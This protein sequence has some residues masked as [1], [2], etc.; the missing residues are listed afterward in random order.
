MS[1]GKKNGRDPKKAKKAGPPTATLPF[2]PTVTPLAASLPA[3]LKHVIAFTGAFGSGCTTAATHVARAFGF[4]CVSLSKVVRTAW[5]EEHPG[6]N[7]E[8]APRAELQAIGDR[9]REENGPAHLVERGLSAHSD[10]PLIVI[11]GI[12]NTAEIDHLRRRFGYN[13]TVIAVLA[14]FKSRWARMRDK[15]HDN[16]NKFLDDDRRDQD[17]DS[18][19]GQQVGLCVDRSDVFLENAPPMDQDGLRDKVTDYVK[20]VTG[21][22]ER[23]PTTEEYFMHMA[24]SA[25]HRSEC[26]KRHVGAIVVDVDGEVAGVGYNENPRGT[27]PCKHEP[28]Y[29]G[30][31]YRDILRE[32]HLIKLTATGTWCPH[33]GAKLSLM[34]KGPFICEACKGNGVKTNLEQS[35]FP[36]RAM[37]WCTAIHAEAAALTSAGARA[38]GGTIYTTTFP[39]FQC[40][41][42]IK[43]AGI[44]QVYYTDP[45]PDA[46]SQ[47]RLLLQKI[48]TK[49]FEGVRSAS[50]ER[51][52]KLAK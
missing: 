15:Y 2:S 14:G 12:R 44:R 20:L 47:G 28:E 29:E 40:T 32:R 23:R 34:L 50:F 10:Q 6:Q 16:L 37:W 46:D 33:C 49:R 41:E 52:F 45:Y 17:E 18:E 43:Q 51:V 30:R 5:K 7:G 4:H 24:F 39:C 3:G 19:F 31:C 25:A 27:L 8:D 1:K 22:I 26:L 35:F 21:A 36:D 38:R 48:E 11:D 13:V 9:L 42:R